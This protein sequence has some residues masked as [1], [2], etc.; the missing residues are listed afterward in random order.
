MIICADD[1]GLREDIDE[2]ILELC[3]LGKLSAVSCMVG[4]ARC[5]SRLMSRLLEHQSRVDIGL[6]L[7][8]TD[9]WLPL[10][11]GTAM[12]VSRYPTFGT[13]LRR[14]LL[15][16]LRADEVF[17]HV[18]DQYELFVRKSGRKPDHIDGHLHVHQLP[19][20]SRGFVDFVLTLTP[21]DR[22]YVRNTCTTVGKIRRAGLPW[23][24][25]GLISRLGVRMKRALRASGLPTN[26]EFSGIYNF[27]DWRRYPEMFP[28]FAACLHDSND[29]LVV[30]PGRTESWRKSEFETLR[31][32]SLSDF[33]LNRFQ[34]DHLHAAAGPQSLS[35]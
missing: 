23:I 13:L 24:K 4:L 32:Y 27:A 6:H 25:A 17:K 21:Q 19:A 34:Y 18:A 1:F 30:H 26:Q 29:I 7:C 10:S 9:E 33:R 8:L 11:S 5:D 31:E 20:V 35:A 15:G 3:G 14:A 28:K 22:P 12:P 16:R 2:A